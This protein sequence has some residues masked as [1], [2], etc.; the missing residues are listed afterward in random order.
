M[1]K[2]EQITNNP[3][4][5]I[6]ILKTAGWSLQMKAIHVFS[7]KLHINAHLNYLLFTWYSCDLDKKVR[8]RNLHKQVYWQTVVPYLWAFTLV[9]FAGWGFGLFRTLVDLPSSL[10]FIMNPSSESG[11]NGELGYGLRDCGRYQSQHEQGIVKP[12]TPVPPITTNTKKHS[13]FLC[14]P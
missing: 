12:L 14:C 8:Q 10:M 7:W 4:V 5:W 6:K 3:F 9:F 13:N 2:T 1:N 11:V